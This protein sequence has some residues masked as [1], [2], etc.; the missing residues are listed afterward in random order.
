MSTHRTMRGTIIDM[1]RI[2]AEN[3]FETAVGNAN[4]NA[5]GDILGP[6]GKIVKTRED[7]MKEYYNSNPKAVKKVNLGEE[8]DSKESE[9]FLRP[10]E[11]ARQ[12]N[13][14]RDQPTQNITQQHQ[15]Q[16]P[17]TNP[18]N[19][20]NFSSKNPNTVPTNIPTQEI[21]DFEPP[22]EIK[23]F[24]EAR[25]FQEINRFEEAEFVEVSQ[26]EEIAPPSNPVR[27]RK[28][29]DKP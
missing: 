27:K 7:L 28:I 12:L 10:Q 21:Q 5:R 14:R 6:G 20:P 9:K 17:F 2:R 16:Q 11:A 26:E 13:P 15:M 19:Q 1:D 25:N 8:K 23:S 4:M 22:V 29:V 24:Q 18:I 3:E